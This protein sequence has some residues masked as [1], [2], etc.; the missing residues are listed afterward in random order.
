MG[1]DA[2]LWKS[3]AW[4]TLTNVFYMPGSLIGAFLSDWVGP[5]NALA[6]GVLLQGIVGFIMAGCYEYLATPK[7]VAAFVVVYGLVA[8]YTLPVAVY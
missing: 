1:E 5:R 2:P 6:I 7:N 3:F 4:N 8:F